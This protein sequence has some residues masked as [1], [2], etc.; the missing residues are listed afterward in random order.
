M[1][2]VSLPMVDVDAELGMR[3]SPSMSPKSRGGSTPRRNS[4]GTPSPTRRL[5]TSPSLRRTSFSDDVKRSYRRTSSNVSN[6]ERGFERRPSVSKPSTSPPLRRPSIL[7]KDESPRIAP[8]AENRHPVRHPGV[9]GFHIASRSKTSLDM[10]SESTRMAT[11]Y[12]NTPRTSVKDVSSRIGRVM[13]KSLV[14]D[15]QA[16]LSCCTVDH[17]KKASLRLMVWLAHNS[18]FSG[19]TTMLT[20]YALFGDDLRLIFTEKTADWIFDITTCVV[21]FVFGL[22][23]ICNTVG[24]A[25]YPRSFFFWLDIISTVTLV[26][27]VPSVSEVVFGDSITSASSGVSSSESNSK[28]GESSEAARAAR[29]SRAG[30]KAGRIVRLLRLVRLVR[31]LKMCGKKND[32]EAAPGYDIDNYDDDEE[33]GPAGESA[34]SKKLSEMT[35]RR[36]IMLVLMIILGVP[37]FE[38]DM[39]GESLS[40]AA[41][42]GADNLFRR[43]CDGVTTY[44]PELSPERQSMYFNSTARRLYEDD[45]MMYVYF[46]NIFCESDEVPDD[47]GSSPVNT[48]GKLYWIGVNSKGGPLSKYVFPSHR[49][50]HDWDAHWRGDTW[51][52]YHC[53]LPAGAQ[54]QLFRNWSDMPVCMADS[55]A[56]TPLTTKSSW[57]S[58][59]ETCLRVPER[60]A[61]YP[62]MK[63]EECSAVDMMFVFDRTMGSRTESILNTCQTLFI[64]FLLAFGAMAFSSDANKLVLTPIERMISKFEKIR[65]NP[66]E[67]MRLRSDEMDP[68]MKAARKYLRS[69]SRQSGISENTS[70]AGSNGDEKSGCRAWL[71]RLVTRI[72][73]GGDPLAGNAPDPTETVILEKAIMR[74]GALLALSFGEV[75]AEIVGR[76]MTGDVSML[77]AMI[78]GRRVEVV[79]AHCAVRNF[80]DT[81]TVLKEQVAIF[82]NSIA[83]IVHMVAHD[84][85]GTTIASFGESFLLVWR[86]ADQPEIKRTRLSDLALIAAAKITAG[87]VNSRGLDEFRTHPG[88]NAVMPGYMVRLGIG[89]HMGSAIEAAIGSEFKIDSSYLGVHVDFAGRLE[90]MTK[91]YGV[92]V[93]L[94]EA[95]VGR[96]SAPIARLC[97]QVDNLYYSPFGRVNNQP[98]P[99]V[100]G[101]R[102]PGTFR[103]YALD[104]DE[105]APFPEP[106]PL[107]S[108][109]TTKVQKYRVQASKRKARKERWSDEKSTLALFETDSDIALM[110]TSYTEDFA[111]RFRMGFLNY[112]SGEWENARDMLAVT[113]NLLPRE[114]GPSVA[115]LRFMERHSFRTPE[116]WMGCRPLSEP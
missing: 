21:I 39:Y 93:L 55:W 85:F 67:A 102:Q 65:M 23:V 18:A 28:A 8:V 25:T 22:E 14:Y 106:L 69:N 97:R 66:L 111:Y 77:D 100:P 32:R 36:V 110:R 58:C 40:S 54:A 34:V 19:L 81:S 83:S 94:S 68:E 76:N 44:L 30:T 88:L 7:R 72:R 11:V 15:R 16:L 33:E 112:E 48:F 116:N 61:V 50:G 84:F 101:E 6:V 78:P 12:G 24:I 98:L 56:G 104:L 5:S 71:G 41:Q 46:H 89:L 70:D 64:C 60:I 109:Q 108:P 115:L 2:R 53:S 47:A 113:R 114:D 52:A 80:S 91:E 105:R 3:R 87:I 74:I 86:F 13:R 96:M 17:F 20:I 38:T 62:S 90:A 27:D 51:N 10:Q 1:P 95:L 92:A 9:I 75:G 99:E 37:F 107:P 103:L 45:F 49:E 82:V 35:T 43:W 4:S 79:V 26:L 42:Y 73:K 59:P 29:M 31:L 63:P 57:C